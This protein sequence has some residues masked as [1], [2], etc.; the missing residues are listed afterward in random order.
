MGLYKRSG[1][2]FY[3]ISFR[4]N[5]R[6]ICESTKTTNK[7][8]AGKIYAK[9]ITEIAEGRWFPNEARKR[10]FE[11]L[12]DRYMRDHSRINKKPKSSL[13]DE[14]SF[15]HLS[16]FFGSL[17]LAE[18]TP[19]RISEYKSS[20]RIEGAKPATLS[21]ELEVL[22]HAFNLAV[23]EWEWVERS[24]FEKIRIDKFN[25]KVE[26]WLTS[27]EEKRLLAAAPLWLREII[28][29]ALNTG[30]RQ[31]EILSLNW[32]QVDLS[33]RT[34]TLLETKNKEIR[35]VPLN[36][37][38]CNM[39]SV[40]GK[41]RH[42]TGYVF[43]SEAGTKIDARN[44]LRAFYKAREEA[45]LEDVRFHD[46]RHSFATRLVQE[47]IDLYVV[48]KL[49]GHKSVTM[50]MRYAHHYAESLR[51]G[52]DILDAAGYNAGKNGYNLATMT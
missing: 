38:V 49:M 13:R 40:K 17:T 37:T 32:P 42:I 44:L 16:E 3:W 30:M 52:V 51:H 34:A 4:L 15:R 9:K 22:R 20:R 31:D 39:L 2:P 41:I 27:E 48:Q 47:N 12:R 21:R 28:I 5:G 6:K 8:L 1:S 36:Q 26:R 25:N 45:K 19:A 33:R 35:T 18:I 43:T 50:T 14:T 24:P 46:L 23:R 7:K 29:F 10:T 11:E